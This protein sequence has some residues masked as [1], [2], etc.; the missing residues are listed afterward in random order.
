VAGVE[1]TLN[2]VPAD[3]TPVSG[4]KLSGGTD[5]DCNALRMKGSGSI[6]YFFNQTSLFDF[7]VPS[8]VLKKIKIWFKDYKFQSNGTCT[9]QVYLQRWFLRQNQNSMLIGASQEVGRLDFLFSTADLVTEGT[10]PNQMYSITRSI[11]WPFS[12]NYQGYTLDVQVVGCDTGPGADWT[13]GLIQ[14]AQFKTSN[15]TNRTDNCATNSILFG[16]PGD[17]EPLLGGTPP[18]TFAPTVALYTYT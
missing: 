14:S 13:I 1:P 12:N 17:P 3:S 2:V 5:W 15:L 18:T 6:A 10:S 8:G 7:S 4:T 11:D 16:G 9:L